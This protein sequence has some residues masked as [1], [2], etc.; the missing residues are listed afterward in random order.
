MSREEGNLD[1]RTT[2]VLFI[3]GFVSIIIILLV[4]VVTVVLCGVKGFM[5]I[6]FEME[7][8]LL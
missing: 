6:V 5:V 8:I 7:C 4:I 3:V 2:F 1:N